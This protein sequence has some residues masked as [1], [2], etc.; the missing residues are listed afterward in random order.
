MTRSV[1]LWLALASVIVPGVAAGQ[2]QDLP[3]FNNAFGVTGIRFD[4]HVA[5][6]RTAGA[7]DGSLIGGSVAAG[8][9]PVTLR[10]T[11]AFRN[12]SADDPLA[13]AD[14]K[15]PVFGASVAYRVFGGGVWPFAINVQGGV[16]F[17]N[18]DEGAIVGDPS[19]IRYVG[20]VG[21]AFRP[22][23]PGITIQPWISGG[24]RVMNFDLD[25][26]DTSTNF[27]LSGGVD[28]TLPSGFGFHVA[29][30]RET[31]DLPVGLGLVDLDRTVT[32]VAFGM[33]WGFHL[34]SSRI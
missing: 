7:G 27:G 13:S 34:P 22:V 10:A 32:T 18:Q 11:A 25:G 4:G 19:V 29:L 24:I 3:V 9:G 26:A 30:D 21:V 2:V 12:L 16:G 31:R 23:V 17:E 5:F 1:A 33:H 14:E 15:F 20:N 8:F 28:L 6:P